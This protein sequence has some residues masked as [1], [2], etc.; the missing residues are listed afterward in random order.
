MVALAH[1][2]H[3]L[4]GSADFAMCISVTDTQT[5]RR[6]D[7]ATCDIYSNR[8]HL[9]HCVHAMWPKNRRKEKEF[10]L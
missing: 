5:N 4:D 1:I 9:I 7:H 10:H 6:T 2:S 8:P 3:H